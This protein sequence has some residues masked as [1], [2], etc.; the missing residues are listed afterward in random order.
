VVGAGLLPRCREPL[1]G[2]RLDFAGSLDDDGDA[3][4]RLGDWDALAGEA[5][6][7]G[8][9][10]AFRPGERAAIA[11]EPPVGTRGAG[12]GDLRDG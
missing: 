12:E 9:L 11:G 10:D 5:L 2:V 6:L 1:P 8:V 4:R 3:I 7:E